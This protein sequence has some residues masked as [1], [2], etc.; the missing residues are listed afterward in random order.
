MVKL[1][2][3]WMQL[4]EFSICKDPTIEINSIPLFFCVVW[5]VF[6]GGIS[7]IRVLSEMQNCMDS[8]QV[9]G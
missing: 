5:V 2:I 1:H 4:C 7:S 9:T 6:I 8:I 3:D